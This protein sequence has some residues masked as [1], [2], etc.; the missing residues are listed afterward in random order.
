MEPSTL[1]AIDIAQS[2][3]LMASVALL[4]LIGLCWAF[5]FHLADAKRNW[6]TGWPYLA[7]GAAVFVICLAIIGAL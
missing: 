1:N 2:L 7:L 5:D 6:K 4:V 3:A